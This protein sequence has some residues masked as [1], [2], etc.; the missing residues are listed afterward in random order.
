[1]KV[2]PKVEALLEIPIE[3][4]F[5]LSENTTTQDINNKNRYWIE[6]PEDWTNQ[7]DK[8]PIIGFR[9]IN[10]QPATRLIDFTL[11]T[12][13]A[14]KTNYQNTIHTK[15]IQFSFMVQ[16]N[17]HID[18]VLNYINRIWREW[19]DSSDNDESVDG[20]K[21]WNEND[22]VFTYNYPEVTQIYD[23]KDYQLMFYVLLN[24]RIPDYQP[25]IDK[26]SFTKISSANVV[27]YN[28][29]LA[30]NVRIDNVLISFALL[31]KCW[32]RHDVLIKS[33]LSYDND[34]FLGRSGDRYDPIKF[35]RLK[36]K[37]KKFWI[38]LYSLVDPERISVFPVDN[39]ENKIMKDDLR[40]ECILCFS[41]NGM[42]N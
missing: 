30:A 41:S 11:H 35:Y 10:I 27:F 12:F 26:L 7:L 1:M 39:V 16:Y 37:D 9:R 42:L 15:N 20:D 3:R 6:L 25:A 21:L 19:I 29:R 24:D 31:I 18:V 38:E 17:E 23:F 22:I 34:F 32:D 14:K 40:L 5:K 28:Q 33:N 13:Y 8:D 4:C 2:E 36:N